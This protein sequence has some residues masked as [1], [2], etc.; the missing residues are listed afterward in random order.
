VN[1]IDAGLLSAAVSACLLTALF[2]ALRLAHVTDWQWWLVLSP[3]WTGAG[4][5]ALAVA[6]V[7]AVMVR[8]AFT[9]SR[10]G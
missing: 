1:R 10:H 3:A 5:L 7:L 9:M 8:V 6:F 2:T 4:L